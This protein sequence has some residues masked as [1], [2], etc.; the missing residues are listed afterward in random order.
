MTCRRYQGYQ[1]INKF[2]LFPKKTLQ[3]RAP[4]LGRGR[5]RFPLGA[6][7]LHFRPP[8]R[9]RHLR[10]SQK[11]LED[12]RGM[13]IQTNSFCFLIRRSKLVLPSLG[14]VGRCSLSERNEESNG[15]GEVPIRRFPTCIL[16]LLVASDIR[17]YL[18]I[19]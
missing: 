12:I 18:R 8:R 9:K 13:S 14:T 1:L 10:I 4:L 3:A 11:I 7:L 17:E 16:G 5:G 6:L 19:F 2:I 15:S